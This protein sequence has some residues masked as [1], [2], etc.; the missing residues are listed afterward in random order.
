[1]NAST[2]DA[3]HIV[4]RPIRFGWGANPRA[5]HIHQV[6]LDMGI[7]AAIGGLVLRSPMMSLSRKK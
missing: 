6:D 4:I 2:S 3:C 5:T 1:M 7:R